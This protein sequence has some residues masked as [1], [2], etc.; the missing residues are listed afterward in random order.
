MSERVLPDR[1]PP[2]F[3]RREWSGAGELDTVT[4]HRRLDDGTLLI[5][6]DVIAADL[7]PD[8]RAMETIQLVPIGLVIYG[9]AVWPNDPHDRALIR[10]WE[11]RGLVFSQCFSVVETEGEVGTHPRAAVTEI[12]REEFEAARERGWADG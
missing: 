3:F 7:A 1:D 11:Q 10:E 6:T 4:V 12:S 5:E 8:M 9:R 2:F